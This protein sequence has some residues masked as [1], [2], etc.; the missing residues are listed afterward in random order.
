M[1]NL[2]LFYKKIKKDGN[3]DF[4]NSLTCREFTKTK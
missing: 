4:K 2:Q 1:Y 3:D